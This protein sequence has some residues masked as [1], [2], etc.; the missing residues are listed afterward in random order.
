[1]HG[2]STLVYPRYISCGAEKFGKESYSSKNVKR[3]LSLYFAPRL[4]SNSVATRTLFK[5]I[6]GPRTLR[7]KI[8]E[9]VYPN[10][11]M[12]IIRS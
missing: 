4:S 1:M 5:T 11:N 9:S 10:V 2:S 7:Y 12:L 8:S 3:G 6:L